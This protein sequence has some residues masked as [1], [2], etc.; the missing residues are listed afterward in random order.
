MPWLRDENPA[1]IAEAI[2]EPGVS[3]QK[4]TL[5][6][7]LAHGNPRKAALVARNLVEQ[8]PIA[9]AYLHKDFGDKMA[10]YFLKTDILKLPSKPDE[11]PR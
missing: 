11:Y 6:E 2:W 10:D 3:V 5:I 9:K 7:L 8:H 4:F 1:K